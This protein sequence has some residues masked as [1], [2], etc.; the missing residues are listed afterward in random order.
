VVQA[1]LRILVGAIADGSAGAV[2]RVRGRRPVAFGR[3]VVPAV[4]VGPGPA[5]E[6]IVQLSRRVH[7]RR[8]V[9]ASVRQ[10]DVR[11]V[12][13]ERVLGHGGWVVVL[14]VRI[15]AL[16]RRHRHGAGR[17]AGRSDGGRTTIQW[18]LGACSVGR[19]P[20]GVRLGVPRTVAGQRGAGRG[21]EARRSGGHAQAH[22]ANRRTVQPRV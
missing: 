19:G 16:R 4:V 7:S 6:V 21:P 8:H 1:L 2:R 18:R 10:A 13:R 5:T 12:P 14:R 20:A 3:G 15:H 22:H 11:D 9:C 17:G